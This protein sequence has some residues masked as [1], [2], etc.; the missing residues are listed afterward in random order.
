M[1]H[2][3][4]F[5]FFSFYLFS[6]CYLKAQTKTF[7]FETYLDIV[8]NHHPMVVIAGLEP[9]IA[10]QKL[11]EV[12][13][14]FDPV[15]S[16]SQDEK[17]FNDT[18]YYAI[19]QSGLKIPTKWGFDL[20]GGFE[21]MDG[22]YLNPENNVP[23]AGL[24]HAGITVPLGEGLLYDKERF[25]LQKAKLFLE[26]SQLERQLMLNELYY[27]A[28]QAYWDWFVAFNSMKIYEDAYQLAKDR[29]NFIIQTYRMGD[30]PNIDTTEA[31]I[32]VQNLKVNY[33]LSKVSF[34]NAG[35][36]LGTYLWLDGFTP[37][38]LDSSH[39]PMLYSEQEGA[40]FSEN[41]LQVLPELLHKHPKMEQVRLKLKAMEA[42]RNWQRNNL[43]P[44]LDL[45][46][47]ILNEPIGG[48]PFAGMSSNNFKWGMKFS[49]PILL[50]QER[51]ALKQTTLEI[52]QLSLDSVLFKTTLFYHASK[53]L[54]QWK[55]DYEQVMTYRVIVSDHLIML[56]GERRR[57]EAGESSVFMVNTREVAYV[58]A[59]IKLVE[60]LNKNHKS[61]I[62]GYYSLGL[63]LPN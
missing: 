20:S 10:K 45:K 37:L 6:P 52:Q 47:N 8:K 9:E 12:R 16:H 43:L 33:E 61:R 24:V 39:A 46:Y 36:L 21:Q 50:R 15:I 49:M 27:E 28:G 4:F 62:A 41:L 2:R 44:T 25:E 29:K 22:T 54:N 40:L 34:L 30:A 23:S 31:N 56:N 38:F 18:R 48:S 57:F 63:P 19:R 35:I 3:I 14:N 53:N 59:Q 17:N 55:T 1:P 5:V 60:F 7:R 26:S 32:Q 13:G 51:G 11:K 58:N 42:Q